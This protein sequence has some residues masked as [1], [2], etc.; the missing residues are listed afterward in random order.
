VQVR[1]LGFQ[2]SLFSKIAKLA[3]RLEQAVESELR[4]SFGL[5]LSQFKALEAL[6]NLGQSTQREIAQVM[7]VT[8]AVV[9]RQAEVLASRGLL[10]QRSNPKSRRENLL[11]LSP[12]GE[13]A[14]LSATRLVI[15]SQQKV[16]KD[17]DLQSETSLNRILDSLV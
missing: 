15:S 8:P 5:T 6:A 17:I 1:N 13:E 7:G 10:T 14:V 12:K 11:E 4:V 9:T 16:L 2:K 3:S